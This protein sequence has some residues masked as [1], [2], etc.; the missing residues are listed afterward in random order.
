MRSFKKKASLMNWFIALLLI[1]FISTAYYAFTKP[2]Q[3]IDHYATPRVNLTTDD[4]HSAQTTL[5][6]I[7]NYWMIWPVLIAAFLIIWAFLSSL[8]Q[9]PNYPMY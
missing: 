3:F 2:F 9:D 5:A 1:M 6:K 8:K 4:G 7:R